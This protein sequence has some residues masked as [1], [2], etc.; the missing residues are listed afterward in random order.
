MAWINILTSVVA[1]L[2][3]WWASRYFR[4]R[5]S[6]LQ[7]VL[8]P[9]PHPVVGS[10]R[11]ISKMQA[12]EPH[13]E[14]VKKYGTMFS[15]AGYFY[16]MR[17]FVTDKEGLRRI[18]VTNG[19]NY[20]RSNF[21]RRFLLDIVGESLLLSPPDVHAKQRRLLSGAFGP[22]KIV[23]FV[24]IFISKSQQMVAKW[25]EL[26]KKSEN[27]TF[28]TSGYAFS[29][30]T[31]DII[32]LAAFD[33]EFDAVRSEIGQNELHK[34]YRTIFSAGT[35]SYISQLIFFLFAG[36]S[37]LP[38]PSPKG[39]Q[40]AVKY[41][42]GAVQK[43]ISQRR[44][45]PGK[46]DKEDLLQLIIDSDGADQASEEELVNHVLTF[47]VAGHETTGTGMLWA[48]LLLSRH[49][50][51][52]DT[53]R[54]ELD[55]KQ[56]DY[57]TIKDC[58][59]LNAVV[60]EILRLYPPVPMLTRIALKDDVI[61]GIGVPSGTLVITST[62]VLHRLEEN[63]ENAENFIP[64]RWLDS[65]SK[66]S[67]LAFQTFS[68]GDYNCIGRRFALY[69]MA[70]IIAVLYTNFDIGVVEKDYKRQSRVTMKPSPELELTIKPRERA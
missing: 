69:E 9:K 65:S 5:M 40:E 52:V 12:A 43:I 19:S 58:S 28:T 13:M 60:K 17:L 15:Y 4:Y 68:L 53:L 36:F 35:G 38:L 66:L 59:Y 21:A 24:D 55:G 10:L 29:L 27:K 63:Y 22:D 26:A 6:P 56:L 34:A 2:V 3:A 16:Q 1:V 32:G 46:S 37:F 61:N 51:V 39:R 41:I 48:A 33:Y 67:S 49:P 7:E 70:V 47:L 44:S 57:A 62:F 30:L 54:R 25:N 20:V 8:G 64:E 14:W 18:F 42:R 23:K 45:N 50:E 11:E 31:L